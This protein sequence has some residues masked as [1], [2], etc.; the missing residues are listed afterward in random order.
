MFYRFI[1]R[2]VLASV[3]GLCLLVLAG[4]NVSPVDAQLEG[5]RTLSPAEYTD[6]FAG[7][8]IKFARRNGGPLDAESYFGTDGSFKG[9]WL[10]Q[11][12]VLNGTWTLNQ[13]HIVLRYVIVG[14]DDGVPFT[15]GTTLQTMYVYPYADGTAEVFSRSSAG[16]SRATQPKP[17]P[18]FQNRARWNRIDREVRAALKAT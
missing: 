7:K 13:S 1:P 15:G 16:P 17:T 10:D 3:A 11:D 12:V 4:C 14:M 8:S 18:G 9:V 6:R 2:A 5:T